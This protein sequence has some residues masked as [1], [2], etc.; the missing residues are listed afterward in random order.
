LSVTV[1]SKLSG[2]AKFALGVYVTLGHAPVTVPFTGAV[3]T[4]DDAIVPSTSLPVSV[5]TF[6]TSST[7]LTLW[8]KATGAS[9]TPPTV[10]LTFAGALTAPLLSVT[11]NSKLS[12]P[13]KFALGVYVTLGH[14]PVTVPFTGTVLTEDDAIV[15]STSLPV[16]VM[17]FAISS[18]ALTLWAKA[19]GASFTAPTVILTFAGALTAPLLSVT[20][21]SK[22]SGPAKFVLGVYVT[23]GHA[24]VTVPFAGAVLTAY[25]TIVPSTSLPVSV[26][27]FA[28]SSTAL[29]L[30]A[31]A[32]GASFTAPTVMLTFAGALTA[33]LLSVTVNSKLSGPAKF[34]FGVYVTLGHAPVTVPF[35]GPVL[36]AYDAIVPSTSP[37]ASVMTFAT[38][39]NA[40]TLCGVATGTLF[41]E[42][43]IVNV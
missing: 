24:P 16:S 11:V 4:E 19:T 33:P 2:P 30:W 17:T 29:T 35:A 26:M 39:S 9:F 7:A 22:L 14:A 31:K 12:G 20:V 13:A 43:T 15:P 18:T 23:L 6:A 41:P 40:L 8:A 10:M 28:T 36:T 32:T 25:D 21:N 5:M 34:A 37:P 3:L 42:T 1:N 38:S 27:T